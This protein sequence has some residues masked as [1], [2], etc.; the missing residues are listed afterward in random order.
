MPEG[1]AVSVVVP[2]KQMGFGVALTETVGPVR[3]PMVNGT[4]HSHPLSDIVAV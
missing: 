4:W 3:L 1:L 2:P